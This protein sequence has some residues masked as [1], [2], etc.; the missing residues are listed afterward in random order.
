MT[1]KQFRKVQEL[2]DNANEENKKKLEI[3]IPEGEF[4]FICRIGSKLSVEEDSKL[5]EIVLKYACKAAGYRDTLEE[6]QEA[7]QTKLKKKDKIIDILAEK[8]A[9]QYNSKPRKCSFKEQKNI[10]CNNYENCVD[11]IKQ[12]V[13]REVEQ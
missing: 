1:E 6:Y 11:C 7:M 4:K 12:Y 5:K 9:K 10:E 13:E 2:I 3:T 8:L